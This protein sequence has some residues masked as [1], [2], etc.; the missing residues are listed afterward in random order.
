MVV[1]VE[2]VCRKL[3]GS[4]GDGVLGG[5]GRGGRMPCLRRA[6]LLEQRYTR[7]RISKPKIIARRDSTGGHARN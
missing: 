5:L 4:G 7:V 2:R 6:S 1:L 3:G